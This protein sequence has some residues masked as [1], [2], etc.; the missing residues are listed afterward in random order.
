MSQMTPSISRREFLKISA[1][2]LGTLAFNPYPDPRYDH[3]YPSYLIGR[4]TV[5]RQAAIYEEPKEHSGI[6]RWTLQDELLNIYYSLTPPEGP[7]Y[8]PVWY[9]VWGGYVH[10]SHIQLVHFTHNTPIKTIPDYGKLAEVTVPYTPAYGY[11]RFDGWQP[12]YRLYYKTTHWITGIDEGPDRNSWYEITSEIDDNLKYFVPTS[13]LRPIADAEIAPISPDVPYEDKRIEVS[14]KTQFLTAFEADQPVFSTKISSGY[15]GQAV[16]V[17]TQTPRGRFHITSKT[18]S[19]HMGSIQA[20]GAPDTYILP[21]VPWTMFFIFE[22]GVA[23]HGT[24]WH[25]NFGVPMSHGCINM[26]N[27]DAKW[28]FR[29]VTPTFGLPINK[30]SDWDSRGYGT[31]LV[32]S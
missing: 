11:N 30:R 32:I 27:E 10:S 21:G 17:G 6:V 16:P 15:G 23:F 5:N 8:N 28:L 24:F 25:N 22:T 2:T 12:K 7:V 20:S 4:V 29:W 13:H 26:A 19:K 31:Q 9:R 3:Q 18:P 1:L 14:L